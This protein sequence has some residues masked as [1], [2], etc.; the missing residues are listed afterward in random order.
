MFSIMLQAELSLFIEYV[1]ENLLISVT[2]LTAVLVRDTISETWFQLCWPVTYSRNKNH[3]CHCRHCCVC[4]IANN[5]H[6][7]LDF[8]L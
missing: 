1:L 6:K 7:V 2:L 3:G 8:P 4:G 5:L